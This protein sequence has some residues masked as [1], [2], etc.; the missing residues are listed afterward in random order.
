MGVNARQKIPVEVCAKLNI[1]LGAAEDAQGDDVEPE[2]KSYTRAEGAVDLRVVGEAGDVPAEGQGGEEPHGGGGDG[3]REGAPPRLPDRDAHV[4][5]EGDE[6]DAAGEGDRPADDQGDDVDRGA[7][8]GYDVH[9]EP[10]R[11]DVTEDDQR[12]GNGKWDE[13]EGDEGVGAATAAPEG[14]AFGREMV[15]AAEALHKRGDDAGGSGEADE[16]GEDEGVCGLGI[17]GRGVEVAFEQGG[18]VRGENA[19][20]EGAE[21]RSDGGGIGEQGDDGRGDDQ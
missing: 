15:G 7:D 11:D 12:A 5:D 21:L 6:A 1:E 20:E 13:G 9:G 3:S 17:V 10:G 8:G 16:E 2:E 14:P 4:V 18:N 19:I